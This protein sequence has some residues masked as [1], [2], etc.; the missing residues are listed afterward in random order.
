MIV[1]CLWLCAFACCVV[2]QPALPSLAS[3]TRIF[4]SDQALY[5]YIK[6]PGYNREEGKPQV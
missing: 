4:A 6:D 3:R 1:T 2:L 5:D